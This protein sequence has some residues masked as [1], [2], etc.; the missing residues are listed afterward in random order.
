MKQKVQTYRCPKCWKIEEYGEPSR[1]PRHCPNCKTVVMV[2]IG[3][4]VVEQ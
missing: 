3:S 4:R 2:R 1:S